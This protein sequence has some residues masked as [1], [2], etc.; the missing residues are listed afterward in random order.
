MRCLHMY[1]RLYYFR[2]FH[3]FNYQKFLSFWIRFILWISF[4]EAILAMFP[5]RMTDWSAFFRAFIVLSQWQCTSNGIIIRHNS[6]NKITRAQRSFGSKRMN[7]A[8]VFLA[9]VWIM[10][11]CISLCPGPT[12]KQ[13]I[14]RWTKLSLYTYIKM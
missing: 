8:L 9:K 1:W 2:L 12:Q 4:W 11:H 13:M 7:I 3:L 5:I 10:R 14:C 6:S